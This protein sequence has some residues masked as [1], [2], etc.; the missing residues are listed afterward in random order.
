MSTPLIGRVLDLHPVQARAGFVAARR[1]LRHDAFEA[2][3]A[4][5]AKHRLADSYLFVFNGRKL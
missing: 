2:E 3:A 4:G 1:A 5:V